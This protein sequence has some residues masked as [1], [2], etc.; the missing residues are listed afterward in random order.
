MSSIAKLAIE[1]MIRDRNPV[2]LTTAKL[3]A[4]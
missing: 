2:T 1:N 3:A 4:N